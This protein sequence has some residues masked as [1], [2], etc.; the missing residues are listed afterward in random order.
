MI[1]EVKKRD[2]NM[3]TSYTSKAALRSRIV[4][5]VTRG[6]LE[7][8]KNEIVKKLIYGERFPY[9]SGRG[10]DAVPNVVWGI[11]LRGVK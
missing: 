2:L 9:I 8:V 7:N 4:L 6:Q 1:W 5:S 10:K 11:K 3:P